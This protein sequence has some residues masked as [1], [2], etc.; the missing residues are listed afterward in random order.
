M[1]AL[2]A[3]LVFIATGVFPPDQV[4]VV[5]LDTI[6]REV[7]H[8]QPLPCSLALKAASVLREPIFLKLA[9]LGLST[10]KHNL[11]V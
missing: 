6:A 3:L 9:R 7:L 1:I 5:I 8:L 11:E 4:G 10:T 2:L